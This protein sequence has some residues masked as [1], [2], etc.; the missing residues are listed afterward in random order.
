MKKRYFIP[1]CVLIAAAL[2]FVIFALGHPESAFSPDSRIAGILYGL[3]VDMVVLLIFLAFCKKANGLNILTL[4]LE[5]GAVFFLV[6]TILDLFP[7]G[8]TGWPLVAALGLN[9]IAVLLNLNQKKK[10]DPQARPETGT[11]RRRAT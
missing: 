4:I 9:C 5:L 11:E 2:G 10:P 1:A 8:R 6:Q 7:N 3:Y